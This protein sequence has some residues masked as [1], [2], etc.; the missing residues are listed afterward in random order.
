MKMNKWISVNDKLPPNDLTDYL[1]IDKYNI[2]HVARLHKERY[3]GKD[4]KSYKGYIWLNRDRLIR[5]II[6]W[7]ELPK[8]PKLK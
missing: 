6:Y 4:C 5:D 7:M 2:Y 8:G 3:F 1:I